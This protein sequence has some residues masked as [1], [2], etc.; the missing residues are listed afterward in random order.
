M[1]V[2]G[3]GFATVDVLA[4]VPRLPRPDEVYRVLGSSVQGG[5]PVATALV[6]LA[7]LGG[8][9]AYLGAVGG[10]DWGR[11]IL[12]DFERNGVDASCVSV[13]PEGT[14]TLSIILVDGPTGARSILYD[15]GHTVPLELDAAAAGLVRSARILHLD[16]WH[17]GAAIAAARIAREAGVTV[18]FD[19]GAGERWREVDELLPLVDELIVARQFAR[20]VTGE[21]DPLLAG[22]ALCCHTGAREV[23][24]TDGA[25]GCWSWSGG[26]ALY[27]PAYGVNVVD[28]TGAGDVYHGA[29]LYALLQGWPPE[30]RIKFASATAALKCT[31]PGGRQ[32]IPTLQRVHQ[33]LQERK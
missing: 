31:Q 27:V 13:D 21:D 3:L 6:T 20:N 28:T 8:S 1:D 22:P 30:Q 16:G 15:P 9:V 26:A 19:G 18:S 7:R 11:F 12:E 29:Y 10:D 5:G 25:S 4:T 14:S 23:V 24:I 2:V 32:G 33:F 17:I